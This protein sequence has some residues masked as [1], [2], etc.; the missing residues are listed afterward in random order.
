MSSPFYYV[1][2]S[3][4]HSVDVLFRFA[5]K[6]CIVSCNAYLGMPMHHNAS[7]TARMLQKWALVLVK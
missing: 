1:T 6:Q 3:I 4:L 2:E 7:H 5:L